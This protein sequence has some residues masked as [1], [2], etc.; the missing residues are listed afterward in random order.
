VD[1]SALVVIN[2]NA[3]FLGPMANAQNTNGV[4]LGDTITHLPYYS[5]SIISNTQPYTSLPYINS[6]GPYANYLN[7]ALGTASDST[8]I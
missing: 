5:C 6:G 2:P 4:P 8:V 3:S 1:G 7:S